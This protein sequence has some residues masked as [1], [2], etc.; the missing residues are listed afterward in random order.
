MISEDL[1]RHI[2]T[3]ANLI[4]NEFRYGSVKWA[5]LICEARRLY[6]LGILDDISLEDYEILESDIG[7]PIG[8]NGES[9]LL[10]VPYP[11]HDEPG[12]YFVY[13]LDNESV[14]KIFFDDR[15]MDAAHS[16]DER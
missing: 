4:N 6:R 8:F 16:M 5:E 1:A 10:E 15:Q 14:Q 2:E 3:G 11:V 13:V 12:K 7:E 9:V